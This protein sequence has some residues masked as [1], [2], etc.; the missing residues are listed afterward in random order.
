M[1]INIQA[2]V[3]SSG[4]LR[5]SS[6]NSDLSGMHFIGLLLAKLA[7]A[8]VAV[9][10]AGDSE[11]ANFSWD[12]AAG[13]LSY[14][15]N[16]SGNAQDNVS[17]T[18]GGTV[19]FVDSLVAG[20]SG[21]AQSDQ[22][23]Y[24]DILNAIKEVVDHIDGEVTAGENSA[25]RNASIRDSIEAARMTADLILRR[26]TARTRLD[27]LPKVVKNKAVVEN[28]NRVLTSLDGALDEVVGHGAEL[29]PNTTVRHIVADSIA[30]EAAHD[31]ANQPAEETEG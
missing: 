1:S 20:V 31:D 8:G 29:L 16:G 24:T 26:Q 22:H 6:D 4:S 2:K 25:Y 15:I 5:L 14:T 12:S 3:S 7:A 18:N 17:T 23:D 28:T 11:V 27:L 13:R 21:Q 19:A 30:D 9:S 10:Y